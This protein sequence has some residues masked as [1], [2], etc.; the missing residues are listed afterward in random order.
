MKAA[1]LPSPMGLGAGLGAR[2]MGTPAPPKPSGVRGSLTPKPPTTPAA[3]TTPA[4]P[5]PSPA[6]VPSA[7]SLGPAA[8]GPPAGS[9]TWLKRRTNNWIGRSVNR[10]YHGL[11]ALPYAAGGIVA[12][13]LGT[14][15]DAIDQGA[16]AVGDF[17]GH[18]LS[19]APAITKLPTQYPNGQPRL[20]PSPG[21]PFPAFAGKPSEFLEDPNL[22]GAKGIRR[23]GTDTVRAA[24]QDIGTA[25]NPLSTGALART[26][27]FPSALTA[28]RD[29]A[30][31]QMRRDN[32]GL[33]GHVMA[34][35]TELG[36]RVGGV[37]AAGVPVALA[38]PFVAGAA[39][40]PSLPTW[41]APTMPS[42]GLGTGGWGLNA[43]GVTGALGT[44]ASTAAM[45]G[46]QIYNTARD[47]L[48]GPKAA[49][50]GPAP[51][52]RAL[53]DSLPAGG[54]PATPAAPAAPVAPPAAPAAPTA[55]TAPAAAQP[56]RSV[57]DRSPGPANP[58]LDKIQQASV[59]PQA[60]ADAAKQA[61]QAW[62]GI[63]GIGQQLESKAITPEQAG[64][65]TT[66]HL[67]DFVASHAKASGIDPNQLKTQVA[68][69]LEG[70]QLDQNEVQT[71]AAQ[72]APKVQPFGI[73]DVGKFIT[74]NPMQA[75]ALAIGI[76]M[77]VLGIGQGLFG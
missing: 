24:G 14:V 7:A 76:P 36:D 38:A 73:N 20:D 66:Q 74:D 18:P 59:H 1:A 54:P 25:V 37:A 43:A 28:Q 4:T 75:A 41:L 71:L 13:T 15:G 52:P 50:G 63:Q 68:G 27:S 44:G 3:V 57:M 12:R 61:P 29:A 21:A 33:L 23:L 40:A 32:P 60:M 58:D 77:A 39:G 42:I 47:Y 46:Q 31:T 16:D 26:N 8:A 30:T 19:S 49:P 62:A 2:L 64:T 67:D 69:M 35:P 17:Y 22:E 56:A 65:Q 72:L 10:A 55:P 5:K 11:R 48:R 9:S 70:G 53:A 6:S 51:E 45:Y 34:T